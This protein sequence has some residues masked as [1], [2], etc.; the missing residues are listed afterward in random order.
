MMILAT[1]KSRTFEPFNPLRKVTT[2][3]VPMLIEPLCSSD[4]KS[5]LN[6]SLAPKITPYFDAA[7][8]GLL[9]LE[10]FNLPYIFNLTFSLTDALSPVTFNLP[11]L[12]TLIVPAASATIPSTVPVTFISE[13]LLTVASDDKAKV[14]LTFNT[15]VS[16]LSILAF[17]SSERLSS[18]NVNVP[19]FVIFELNLLPTEATFIVF[20]FVI[21][22]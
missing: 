2:P 19:R 12:E 21:E 15:P 1:F 17:A 5:C 18:A 22:L 6:S 9:S 7:S 11:V 3:F 8:C 20:T 4:A 10:T 13:A 16:L 14:P